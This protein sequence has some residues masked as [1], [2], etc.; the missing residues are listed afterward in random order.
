MQN[1]MV[2]SIMVKKQNKK[3]VPKR[4]QNPTNFTYFMIMSKTEKLHIYFT[5]FDNFS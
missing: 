2:I 5:F 1:F 3:I 4:R